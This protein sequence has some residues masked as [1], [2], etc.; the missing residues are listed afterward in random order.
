MEGTNV[1]FRREVSDP[2]RPPLN[3]FPA[4]QNGSFLANPSKST[5]FFDPAKPSS[6]L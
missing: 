4:E 1:M 6:K 3:P 2:A 5:D